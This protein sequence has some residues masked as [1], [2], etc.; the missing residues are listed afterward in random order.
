[1]LSESYLG[2]P[3]LAAY[4]PAIDKLYPP[5]SVEWAGQFYDD[6][7]RIIGPP[8]PRAKRPRGLER[9]S[10]A[11]RTRGFTHETALDKTGHVT[12]S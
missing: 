1:M 10:D 6:G 11:H 5:E 12:V 8:M 4:V 2:K 3:L 7:M 9:G